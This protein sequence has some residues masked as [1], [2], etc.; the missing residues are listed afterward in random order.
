MKECVLWNKKQGMWFLGN[1]S[2]SG[3]GFPLTTWVQIEDKSIHTP[4]LVWKSIAAC[5]RFR[6]KFECLSE[7]VPLP[8]ERYRALIREEEK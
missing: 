5:D 4:V 1:I 3:N 8:L 7:T 6:K 2:Y